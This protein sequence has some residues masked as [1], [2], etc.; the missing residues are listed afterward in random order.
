MKRSRCRLG[1]ALVLGGLASVGGLVSCL[2]LGFAGLG[3]AL[4]FWMEFELDPASFQSSSVWSPDGTRV[5]VSPHRL[6]RGNAT[7]FALDG[8]APRE[9]PVPGSFNASFSPHGDSIVFES[10]DGKQAGL[11]IAASVG[12]APMQIAL[13][14][15][16]ERF[17][18]VWSPDGQWIAHQSDLQ[19]DLVSV[20]RS[21]RRRL[22]PGSFPAWSP[23]GRFLAASW[24]DEDT[25]RIRIF[26]LESG[27]ACSLTEGFMPS[28]SPD[29]TRI[30][31][32]DREAEPGSL[33]NTVF[34][35]GADGS[36]RR[37]VVGAAWMPRWSP[38]GGSILFVR[39]RA[40]DDRTLVVI[41]S[42]GT[43]ER[44][45]VEGAHWGH[46]SPDGRRVAFGR[47]GDEVFVIETDGTGERS[48]GRF[49]ASQP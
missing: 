3:Q 37:P 45:L 35:M 44:A 15:D 10:S 34:V 42:D 5:L 1:A 8:S 47:R 16:W 23:D 20:D 38:D 41:S 9:L 28:W 18:P 39:V 40:F 29:G 19:L 43:G 31:F 21:Q 22:G 25:P 2:D 33:G 48:L 32:L 30:L 13:S 46:W 27:T 24:R 36:D 6:L 7:C 4:A 17:A 26:D 14:H 49:L 12:S 11:W